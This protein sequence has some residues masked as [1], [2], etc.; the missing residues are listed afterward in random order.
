MQRRNPRSPRRGLVAHRLAEVKATIKTRAD[1]A[2]DPSWLGAG[3]LRYW[4]EAEHRELL[5]AFPL[6]EPRPAG[7]RLDRFVREHGRTRHA[8][9]WQWQDAKRYCDGRSTAAS[10]EARPAQPAVAPPS[11]FRGH[12]AARGRRGPVHGVA[13]PRPCLGGDHGQLLR[14]RPARE[15]APGGL[16]DGCRTGCC[17]DLSW[18]RP[19]NRKA[20]RATGGPISCVR[21]GEP[22]EIR[23]L[24][25]GIKSPPLYR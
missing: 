7:E 15:A 5:E 11:T 3:P 9:A 13:R 1:L 10:A 23:T 16:E 19:D 18:V 24:N 2:E 22:A 25:L 21:S 20:L 8:V 17:R 6:G 12:R 4:T 14:A